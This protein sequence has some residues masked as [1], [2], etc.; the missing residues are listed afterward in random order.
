MKQAAV[1]IGILATLIIV[2]GCSRG[3]FEDAAE[4]SAPSQRLMAQAPQADGYAPAAGEAADMATSTTAAGNV[5]LAVAGASQGNPERYLIRNAW[6]TLETEDP[7]RT[8][9]SIQRSIQDAGGYVSNL[10]EAQNPYGNRQITLSVRVPESAL[11]AA[12]ATLDSLG[13]VMNKRITTQDVTEEF[14]DLDARLRNMKRAEERILEH[15]DRTGDLEDII[16][17]EHELTRIRQQVEQMEGRLRFLDHRVRYSTIELAIQE[18]P[19]AQPVVPAATFSTGQVFSEAVRSLVAW[20]QGL[21]SAAIWLG[22]WA[23]VWLP[24]VLVLIFA[25]R[26]IRRGFA[27]AK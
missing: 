7:R 12:L 11:D 10:S 25:G 3:A 2:A 27:T 14:V 18:K 6:L 23:V 26:R 24:V 19:K 21:W 15:L 22:V 13:K 20:S 16:K 4:E 9:E 1:V 17:V 5:A 8:L